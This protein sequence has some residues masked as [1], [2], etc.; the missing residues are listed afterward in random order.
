MQDT[1]ITNIKNRLPNNAKLHEVLINRHNKCRMMATASCF[2]GAPCQR[3]TS[4]PARTARGAL[5]RAPAVVCA[6][7]RPLHKVFTVEKATPELKAELGVSSWGVW[8]TE[9]TA[10][11][12]TGVK[13]PLKVY[14]VREP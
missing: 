10:R 13:S 11:Y 7:G 6:G 2:G 9:G 3:V 1:Y 5:R 14:D 4:M 8:Q 12:K